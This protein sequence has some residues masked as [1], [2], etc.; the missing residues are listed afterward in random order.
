MV[1]LKFWEKK[2]GSS[3]A[4]SNNPTIVEAK[5]MLGMFEVVRELGRGSMSVVYLG[6]DPI[7]NREAAIKTM[8]L[9]NVF[10]EKALGDAKSQFWHEA[11][12]LTW[13]NHPNIV[14]IYDVGEDHGFAYI[15]MEFLSGEKLT[16][17][18]S[19]D[20]LLPL[21]KVLD[22]MARSA[23]AL[24]YAHEQNVIH[25]DIKPGNIMYDRVSNTV[26]VI[27]FGISI[28]TN[29]SAGK[30]S[31]IGTPLYMSPEQVMGKQINGLSDLFSLGSSLYQLVSGHLPFEGATDVDV[32]RRIAKEPHKNILS[33]KPDLPPCVC[34]IIDRAL[35]KD[36]VNR[37][38]S[39]YEMAEA[40]R[41]C[42]AHL[43]E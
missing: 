36:M 13:L 34:A 32:M 6:R 18:T 43:V 28:L 1:G 25:R 27:D 24:D 42:A 4:H 31:V 22:I 23:D 5:D 8:V 21:I 29:L 30:G 37:Y 2:S 12:I 20:N 10:N 14:S 11:K 33:V 39:G 9:A 19:T 26:K 7:S 35:A 41:Q 38:Q 40:I 15:A 16:R 3:S 17:F